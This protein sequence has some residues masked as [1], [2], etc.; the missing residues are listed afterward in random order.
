MAPASPPRKRTEFPRKYVLA[1]KSITG[2]R[3]HHHR[4]AVAEVAAAGEAAAF[5]TTYAVAAMASALSNDH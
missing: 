5:A 2:F 4:P 3:Y 1:I